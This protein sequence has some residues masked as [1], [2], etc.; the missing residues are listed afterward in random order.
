MRKLLTIFYIMASVAFL[1][2]LWPE[3]PAFPQPPE[4]AVQSNEPADTE[5][6]LR[7]AYFTDMSRDEVISHYLSQFENVVTQRFNYPPEEAQTI[8]RDQTRS[9]YLEELSHPFRESVY[10]NGFIPQEDKDKIIIGDT[11][12]YQKITIKYVPTSRFV[13]ISLGLATVTMA[14]L[15]LI[16]S[17][18]FL[19]KIFHIV[20]NSIKIT[21]E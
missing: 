15:V 9:W 13:R 14:Y 4:L 6:P 16:S 5:T 19:P 10:I 11:S 18:H 17:I 2:Y 8:I 7:R 21:L 20:H 3:S 12:Y 1:V